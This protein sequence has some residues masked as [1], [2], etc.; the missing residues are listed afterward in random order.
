MSSL[1][2]IT[3]IASGILYGLMALAFTFLFRTAGIPNLA[4]GAMGTF[5]A[6]LALKIYAPIGL[7]YWAG[8]LIAMLLGMAMG[9]ASE[10]LVFRRLRG[11]DPLV[12]LVATIGLNL[13]LFGVAQ[14]LWAANEPYRFP[15]AYSPSGTV[16]V[17]GLSPQAVAIFIATAVVL[18]LLSALLYRS[19]MGREIRAVAED[20]AAA[21]AIGLSVARAHLIVWMLAAAIIGLAAILF[22]PLL[23]LDTS[24]LSLV[25]YKAMGAAV[26]GGLGSLV[27]A[28][29]GG[30][31]LGLIENLV[32]P[33]APSARDAAAFVVIVLVLLLRPQ[34]LFGRT[35][36]KKI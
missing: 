19:Q 13:L 3:G 25:M 26:L 33:F 14:Y 5:V 27:G 15:G 4:I 32:V 24:V 28:V 23:L 35:Q 12:F 20:P 17:D 31:L 8:V 16:I 21:H 1:L 18:G 2:I 7:P 34:G 6:L 30:L 10:L 9:A 11:A 36:I 29:V 22:A